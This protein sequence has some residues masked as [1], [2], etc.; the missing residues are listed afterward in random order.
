M[1]VLPY[2]GNLWLA[3]RRCKSAAFLERTLSTTNM[4]A[5]RSLARA[6]Q[7]A[8]RRASLQYVVR[9]AFSTVGE[10]EDDVAAPVIEENGRIA[11]TSIAQVRCAMD[12]VAMAN[13]TGSS[14]WT[15]MVYAPDKI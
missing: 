1:L 2:L 13:G 5:I 15:R 11:A 3:G 6:V 7:Q 9:A 4:L 10:S 12:S 14:Q 8:Q